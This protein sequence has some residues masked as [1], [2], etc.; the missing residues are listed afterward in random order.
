M[1]REVKLRNTVCDEIAL[2]ILCRQYSR[3]AIVYATKGVWTTI[4]HANWSSPEIEANCDLMFIHTDKGLTLCKKIL[5]SMSKND[6]PG[7]ADNAAKA[8]VKTKQKTCSIHTVIKE[9]E[10][11]ERDKL[12][13]VSAKLNIDNILPDTDRS[14]NTRRTTPLRRRQNVRE[15][16]PSCENFNYSD[17]LD[18]H[19]LD[20]PPNKKSK[21]KNMPQTL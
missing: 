15:Q 3:H 1:D 14:H 5:D 12:N 6:E 10:E 4:Q 8:P 16:R 18:E 17:N 13:K 7:T 20:A 11:R 21:K 19:H 2:Y 9:T